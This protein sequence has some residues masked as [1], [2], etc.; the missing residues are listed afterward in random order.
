MEI[1][2]SYNTIK[3]AAFLYLSLPLFAFCLG[4][5][6]ICIAIPAAA[7][8]AFALFC[9]LRSKEEKTNIKQ[10]FHIKVWEAAVLFGVMLL[11][12]YLG[13]LN[14]FFYQ[15]S[16]WPYRNA[17]FRDL[18]EYNWPVVYEETSSALVYYVGF[19]LPPAVIAKA[20]KWISGSSDA[21][22]LAGRMALWVWAAIGTTLTSLLLM[23]YVKADTRIKRLI[24]AAIFI[25]FSG[26]DLLGAWFSGTLQ[27]VLSTDVLHMEWWN[28]SANQFSS[29]TTCLF[30][31]F[32]QSVLP[33]LAVICFLL[34]KD[35]R[36]YFFLGTACLTTG[37]FSFIGLVICMFAKWGTRLY[38]A[39]K[40]KKEKKNLCG[41]ISASNITLGCL[42]MP[43][44]LLFYIGNNSL[45]KRGTSV[46][47]AAVENAVLSSANTK[48]TFLTQ[49][50]EYISPSLVLFY[51]FE[52]GI[53]VFLLRQTFR[54]D[55]L[56]HTVAVSLFWIPYVRVGESTD[57]CMRASI[58]GIFILMTF[59]AKYIIQGIGYFKTARRE[60]KKR[61]MALAAA[62]LVGAFTPAVE[63]YRGIYTAVDKGTVLLENDTIGSIASLGITGNFSSS[64]Y[65]EK[66]FFKYL[67]KPSGKVMIDLKDGIYYAEKTNKDK[68]E[69]EFRWCQK[70][71][72]MEIFVDQD[73]EQDIQFQVV[74]GMIEEIS[75]PYEVT[76]TIDG[77]KY[78]YEVDEAAEKITIPLSLTRGVH[79][80]EMTTDRKKVYAPEDSRTLY[81]TISG[82]RLL[83][84]DGEIL[85][86]EAA[87]LPKKEQE[88]K[89]LS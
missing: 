35:A 28:T 21:A 60:T 3:K 88:A 56:F 27:Y 46:D 67:A 1:K 52:V 5:L 49:L 41:A 85:F 47:T 68:T 75:E 81:F 74:M 9:A 15:S 50:A 55:V 77:E 42:V 84:S 63:I 43:M 86:G 25:G 64:D 30:W 58:P 24:T 36:N 8:V 61:Y 65:L 31:V 38:N 82:L 48:E 17:I 6:R 18:I 37:P 33:W 20:V 62:L 71:G 70:T 14:G 69:K 72:T 4:F 66:T 10:G 57:F 76:I 79:S 34:E 39:I 80:V 7:I 11:W 78:R 51:I 19:W 12:G 26:L 2:M 83:D 44:L 40:H 54:K 53:Y 87:R 45:A 16:D 23:V 59:C 32:N 29:I 13:G 73:G 22:W 89:L